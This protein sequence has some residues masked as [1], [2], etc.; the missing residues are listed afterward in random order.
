MEDQYWSIVWFQYI[1][2]FGVFMNVWFNEV[3]FV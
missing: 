3:G 2:Q 1:V